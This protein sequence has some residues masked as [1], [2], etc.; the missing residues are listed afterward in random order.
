MSANRSFIGGFLIL[1]VAI[2]VVGYLLGLFSIAIIPVPSDNASLAFLALAL[3]LIVGALIV[4]L[5]FA[6]MLFSRTAKTQ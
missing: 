3:G 1:G 4:A 2:F 6:I 5:V